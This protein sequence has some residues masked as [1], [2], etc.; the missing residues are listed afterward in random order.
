VNKAHNKNTITTKQFLPPIEA[1]VRIHPAAIKM[2]LR[3]DIGL[4]VMIFPPTH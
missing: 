2:G 3:S 4:A 1:A